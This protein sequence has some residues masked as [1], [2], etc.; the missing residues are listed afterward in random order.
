MKRSVLQKI[1]II[2]IVLFPAIVLAQSPIINV[3]DVGLP[4]QRTSTF[5]GI[6]EDIIM[7]IFL[8]V[9]GVLAVLFLIIGGFQYMLAGANE[10]LAK[11]GKDTIRYAIIGLIIVILSYVIIQVVVNAL[12]CNTVWC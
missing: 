8:P 3:P 12:T 11:R 2:A 9:T 7:G 1:A 4:G 6:V 10:S 5:G